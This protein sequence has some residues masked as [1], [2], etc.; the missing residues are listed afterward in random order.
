MGNEKV[1]LRRR[2]VAEFLNISTTTMWR[3]QHDRDAGFPK[4]R[5]FGSGLKS[6]Y[7]KSEIEEWVRRRAKTHDGMS[8]AS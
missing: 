2:E 3:L 1:F 6:V 5:N 8:L 7:L 4:A